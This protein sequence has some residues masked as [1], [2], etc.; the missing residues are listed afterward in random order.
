[1]PDLP[2]P[3][4]IHP[5][6][7]GFKGIHGQFDRGAFERYARRKG[8]LPVTIEAW[9]TRAAVIELRGRLKGGTAGAY[10]GYSLGAQTVNA[11]MCSMLPK[12][13]FATTLGAYYPVHLPCLK[14][15]PNWNNYPDQ[16]SGPNTDAALVRGEGRRLRS[17]H[18]RIQAEV[19]AR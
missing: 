10:Y 8:M 5:I 15:F 17:G 16:S 19:A 12:P 18:D 4:I 1:M 14:R 2:P 11:V 9:P 6:M 3:A 7:Y 13:Q